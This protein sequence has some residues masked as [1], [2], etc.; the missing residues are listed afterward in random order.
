MARLSA[1]EWDAF[2]QRYPDAHLLQSS[3]WGELKAA[4]GWQV[5]RVAVGEAGVQVLFR[6]LP[7]GFS[8]AYVPKGPLG[9]GWHDLWLEVDA[10]CRRRRA[11]FLKV[12]PD[13]PEPLPEQVQADLVGFLP[14][15][16]TVQPRRTIVVSL[17]GSEEEL[18][19]RM[20]Q[21]TRYNVRLA[22]KKGV[23]VRPWDDLV[24]FQRMMATTG[25]RD[26]FGVH[27][28]AY[29]RRA[30]ELFS[31][32]GGCALLAAEFQ[33][34]PLAALMVFAR[35]K[36][37]WYFYGASTDQE[38]NRMPTYLLQWQAMRWARSRGCAQYDLWGVPDADEA[39]LESQFEGRS[40][41]L[42]GVYRF[43]RGF[44]GQLVRTAGAWDRIYMPGLYALYR[45]WIARRQTVTAGP[46]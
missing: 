1:A 38:R 3:A 23:V 8:L 2:L 7:A 15:R 40:D 34:R 4:F 5:E 29:Y 13:F 35:G 19:A 21:K 39:T 45:W 36:R 32:S 41:G 30:Y 11:I 14:S 17:E 37:A 22:E 46:G 33:G 25:Q 28:L 20:K 18:L 9:R 27:S 24:A 12:E 44:G 43:K 16:H 6:S 31:A 26:G 10:V 42:W